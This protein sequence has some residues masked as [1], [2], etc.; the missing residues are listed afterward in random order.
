MDLFDTQLVD[1][2]KSVGLPLK[3]VVIENYRNIK[4]K[5]V[6]FEEDGIV[7]TGRNGLGKTNVIEAIYWALTGVLFNGAGQSHQIGVTPVSADKGIKT[8]V[9][10]EWAVKPFTMEKVFFEK[11]DDEDYKGGETSYYING[12]LEKRNKQ[13]ESVI[14][15]FLGV[16]E[17][18]VRL[19]GTKLRDISLLPFLLNIDYIRT[20]DYKLLRGLITDI[21][22][23][24]DPKGVINENPEMF[25]PLVEPLKRHGLELE[26]LKMSLRS[27]KFGD[28]VKRGVVD[29]INGIEMT[30][31]EM[32]K[33]PEDDIT[34]AEAIENAKLQV[35]ELETELVDLNVSLKHSEEEV[36]KDY[37]LK[38]A[39]SE[40]ELNKLTEAI[41][42]EHEKAVKEYSTEKIDEEIGGLEQSLYA[43]RESLSEVNEEIRKHERDIENLTQSISNKQDKIKTLTADREALVQEWKKAKSPNGQTSEILTCPHCNTEFNISNTKEHQN[44]LYQRLEKI[45]LHGQEIKAE[46]ETIENDIKNLKHEMKTVEADYTMAVKTRDALNT[47]IGN[48]KEQHS[49]KV[50]ERDQRRHNAPEIDYNTKEVSNVRERL[51]ALKTEKNNA[52]L[53]FVSSKQKTKARIGEIERLL[54]EVKE[55]AN[56]VIIKQSFKKRVDEL[57]A[58]LNDQ[59]K[60]L[61]EIDDMLALIAELEKTMFEA[62]DKK[63]VDAFGEDI[64]FKLYKVNIDGSIDTRVCEMLVKDRWGNLVNIKNIN[65]G[66]YPI[67]IVDFLSRVKKHYGIPSSFVFVDEIGNLD[68]EH[69]KMLSE[70]GEQV[71][72]T[73]GSNDPK[74]IERKF[75]Q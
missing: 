15:Q 72:A 19:D 12:A 23:D 55:V 21:V 45:N 75:R 70:L 4:Y 20:I 64:T 52:L 7:L 71:I 50:A 66:I 13:A 61:N 49:T 10:L 28:K 31:E 41:R 63:L 48:I 58:R 69:K 6:I 26:T 18:N 9:K 47:V 2:N 68:D 59:K 60:R 37:D 34:Q 14:R 40:N 5:E 8:K 56:G 53:D 3:R 38:I 46:I 25:S 73:A 17:L 39:K 11:W 32:N 54:P 65:K 29:T 24:I 27:E 22:G 51:Y 30:I 67:R 42:I 74:I 16:E 62:L 33:E 57:T 43:N 1:E 35:K 44:I 36:T